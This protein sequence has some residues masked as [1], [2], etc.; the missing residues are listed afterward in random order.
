MSLYLSRLLLNPRSRQVI[1]EL[2][3][4]YEMHRTLMRAFPKAMDDTKLKAR[5]EF[6]VLFRADVDDREGGVTVYAQSLVEPDWVILEGLNDYFSLDSSARQ[7]EY[8]EVSAGYRRIQSGQLLSFRLRANPTR[9]VGKDDDKLKGKRVELRR[10]EQQLAWLARKGQAKE[11]GAPGGFELAMREVEED[12]GEVRLAPRVTARSEGRQ[13][14]RKREAGNEHATI[15]FSVLFEGLL[16][17][18]DPEVFYLTL[19]RGVGSGKAYG[20]G[21]LSIASPRR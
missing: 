9:R 16:R 7:Y 10:E 12:T 1:S 4:P 5:D 18:T 14:G 3:H 20:F 2:T 17:V 6:G 13:A 8:K 15:H 19:T 21:L 11:D